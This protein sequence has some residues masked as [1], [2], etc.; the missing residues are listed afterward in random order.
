VVGSAIVA[1]IA[2]GGGAEAAAARA[3]DFVRSLREAMKS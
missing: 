3:R 1:P 2:E